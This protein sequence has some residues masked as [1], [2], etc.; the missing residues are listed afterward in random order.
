MGAECCICGEYGAAGLII[1]L[2]IMEESMKGKIYVLH[3]VGR[4]DR[5]G[6]EA[7]IMSLLRRL[8]RTKFQYDI[9]EQTEDICSHDQEIQALGS[10]IYRCPAI[11]L[12]GLNTYRKWW[13]RFF[14]E[15]D[16]YRIVHGHSR[17]SAPIYLREARRAGR[18]T[19]VHCHNNSFGKGIKGII[20]K[21]WQLPLRNL[22]DINLACSHDSG[23]AQ[24]GR[25]NPFTVINNG[26]ESEKFAFNKY[27][28]M[29]M[30]S[31]LSLDGRF[32]V[33]N[34]ARYVEQKNH[35]FL[36]KI[37]RELLS[38]EPEAVLLLIGSGPLEEK[39][40]S[41]AEEMHMAD[42]IIFSGEH[43]N[44]ADYYQAMDV[45][46]LPSLFEGLGIVNIEAQCA[47]LPCFVSDTVAPEAK[48]TNLLRFLSLEE[49]PEKWAAEIIRGWKESGERRTRVKEVQEKG[50]DINWTVGQ[51]Q[52]LYINALE[53]TR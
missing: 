19:I 40:R 9:V 51:L 41:Q 34:V 14:A 25:H 21:I 43:S 24:Y 44:I 53:K 27:K 8:D 5:G 10:V 1:R 38:M 11:S 22:A 6:T 48:V 17:G 42:S 47:G 52:K 3:V 31:E 20:R 15:H 39:I 35:T 23:I 13:R 37:F 18:T 12:L 46:V 26:I 28:R 49:A 4:M 29:E 45:F 32:V 36:L 7:L 16:E 2:E 33:G 30:R 50:F